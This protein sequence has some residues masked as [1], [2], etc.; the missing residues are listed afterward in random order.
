MVYKYI[1]RR[2]CFI[3]ARKIFKLFLVAKQE[4]KKLIIYKKKN[5]QILTFLFDGFTNLKA[6]HDIKNSFKIL[7]KHNI[8]IV[9]LTNGPKKNGI[10][11]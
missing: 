11:L 9:T 1:K 8:K 5:P 4:L 3:D 7:K 2:G 10:N 6:N